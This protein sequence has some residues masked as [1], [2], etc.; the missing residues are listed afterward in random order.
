MA[1]DN[2]GMAADGVFRAGAVSK[3]RG[4]R[5]ARA[6]RLA[7]GKGE[8][9]FFAGQV[10]Q[11][12]LVRGQDERFQSTRLQWLDASC[13]RQSLGGAIMKP[14]TPIE[15]K[16]S[17]SETALERLIELYFAAKRVEDV[18]PPRAARLAQ[19]LRSQS[20]EAGYTQSLAAI[21]VQR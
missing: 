20:A 11:R 5:F 19:G 10:R 17:S 16:F 6:W 8:R 18:S 15:M 2:S 12:R 13:S 4:I 9:I 3:R 1:A 7:L 14:G 21:L